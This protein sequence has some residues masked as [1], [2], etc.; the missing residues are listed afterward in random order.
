M[1]CILFIVSTLNV[2]IAHK[3]YAAHIAHDEANV[4]NIGDVVRIVESSP[5]SKTKIWVAQ[6]KISKSCA[7]LPCQLL[8]YSCFQRSSCSEATGREAGHIKVTL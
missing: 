5:I 4:F 7:L 3:K 2:I 8:R 1:L 6:E